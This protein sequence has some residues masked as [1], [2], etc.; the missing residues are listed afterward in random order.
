MFQEEEVEAASVLRPRNRHM[1]H[2]PYS[3]GQRPRSL[4]IFKGKGHRHLPPDG[5][6]GKQLVD[7]TDQSEVHSVQSE[8]REAVGSSG[9]TPGL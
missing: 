9:Q 3:V 1:S 6:S 2:L 4:S 5:G 7:I 8:G